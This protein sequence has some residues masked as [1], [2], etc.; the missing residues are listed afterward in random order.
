MA[1]E[2]VM[3]AKVFF[4]YTCGYSNRA[5]H[6]LDQLDDVV[7]TWRPF[8]LLQQ[9]RGGAELPVFDQPDLAGNVSLVALAVHEVVRAGGGGPE[10]LP[11]ADVHRLA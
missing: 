3:A 5:R 2:T 1:E 9:N 6:W 7:V 4:D 8:S 11:A 10:W